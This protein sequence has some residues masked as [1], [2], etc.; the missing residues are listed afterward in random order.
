MKNDRKSIKTDKTIKKY[1]IETHV[2]N[3]S[4]KPIDSGEYKEYNYDWK[5]KSGQNVFG[6]YHLAF[7]EQKNEMIRK[8]LLD[9]ALRCAVTI[10]VR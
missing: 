1:I 9:E 8:D 4:L 6:G 7:T 10:G 5:N 3:F 2:C